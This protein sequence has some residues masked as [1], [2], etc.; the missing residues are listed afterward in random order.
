MGSIQLEFCY[1]SHKTNN[2]IYQ[3]KSLAIFQKFSSFK[4]KFGGLIPVF[5]DNVDSKFPKE[6]LM[7]TLGPYADS[8]YETLGK[9]TIL[10]GYTPP[11][12]GKGNL[13][14]KWK[15]VYEP[16]NRMYRAS[17]NGFKNGLLD[18]AFPSGNLYILTQSVIFNPETK[19]KETTVD[20]TFHQL[21]CFVPGM[22]ALGAFTSLPVQKIVDPSENID[23]FESLKEDISA[24]EKERGMSIE[25]MNKIRQSAEID[26]YV[27]KEL[28]ETCYSLYENSPIGL[29]PESVLMNTKSYP[30]LNKTKESKS[31]PYGWSDF[32]VLDDGYHLRPESIESMYILHRLTGDEKYREQAWKIFEGIQKHCRVS[33]GGYTGILSSKTTK[34]SPTEENEKPQYKSPSG[35]KQNANNKMDS[36][37]LAETLK[38][39]YLMYRDNGIDHNDKDARWGGLTDYVF[40]TQAHILKVFGRD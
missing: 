39:L 7:L 6:N 33:T 16:V 32:K 14:P 1:L 36:W 22:L 18:A 12:A 10:T 37:F 21:H 31:Y 13:I 25:E 30:F 20:R 35:I 17:M 4:D 8:Y 19:K 11:Q 24:T 27:A 40:T 15:H 38:Y 28:M 26:L 9:L 29:L 23:V 5:F 3:D 2:S 34:N